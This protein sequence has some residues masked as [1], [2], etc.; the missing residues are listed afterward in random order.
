MLDIYKLLE[1]ILKS[2]F[3]SFS[4]IFL[5]LGKTDERSVNEWKAWKNSSEPFSSRTRGVATRL[6][7]LKPFLRLFGRCARTSNVLK[8]GVY[9]NGPWK[10]FNLST[11]E[12]LH[13]RSKTWIQNAHHG[14]GKPILHNTGNIASIFI[15]Y[16]IILDWEIE[17]LHHSI[18][19]NE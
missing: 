15:E 18:S 7:K 10:T 5:E 8:Q 13:F 11:F 4:L 6:S 9:I 2:N 1:K 3:K 17:K 19:Y 12:H 14:C 16:F